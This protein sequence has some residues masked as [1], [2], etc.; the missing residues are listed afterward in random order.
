MD[1]KPND[2]A[3]ASGELELVAEAVAVL[4]MGKALGVR[5]SASTTDRVC[6]APSCDQT[7]SPVAS[8]WSRSHLCH[9]IDLYPSAHPPYPHS[10]DHR[11]LRMPVLEGIAILPSAIPPSWQLTLG[12]G[13]VS[14]ISIHSGRG[15]GRAI[16]KVDL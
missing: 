16:V 6:G 4:G 8:L 5:M 2:L 1:L 9:R 13:R 14:F 12:G 11:A 7:I 10:K 15:L 3:G